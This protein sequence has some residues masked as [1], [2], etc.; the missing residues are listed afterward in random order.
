LLG[1]AI[2]GA[3]VSAAAC[4]GP[5]SAP[6]STRPPATV[7][8]STTDAAAPDRPSFDETF[9][10]NDE[11][12]PNRTD[13]DGTSYAVTGGQYLV[14]LRAGSMRYIRP[15]A[16]AQRADLRGDVAVSAQV[17]VPRGTGYAVGVACRLDTSNN[18]YLGRLGGDGT[19]L[20]VRRA[21]NGPEA[22]LANGPAQPP[23]LDPRVPVQLLL[24]CR[25]QGGVMS[26]ELTV[27][28]RPRVW[29]VDPHP[30]PENPPGIYAAAGLSAPTSSFA[31]DNVSVRPD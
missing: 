4:G 30:L 12:W 19:S 10:N 21:D 6:G 16:L 20:I 29:A 14:T 23:Q 28:G 26:V 31:F 22:V 13:P 15:G 24:T 8:P 18:Y 11:D 7:V 9:G 1:T 27:D 17:R 5:S 25:E 2:V 3:L